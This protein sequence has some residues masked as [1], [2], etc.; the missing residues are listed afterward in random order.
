MQLT[1]CQRGTVGFEPTNQTVWAHHC[2]PYVSASSRSNKFCRYIYKG[3]LNST[4]L[5]NFGLPM[6]FHGIEPHLF[7]PDLC[8]RV[9]I[10]PTFLSGQ[11]IEPCIITSEKCNHLCSQHQCV[12]PF[13]HQII[14]YLFV[15]YCATLH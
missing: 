11:G 3:R 5:C 13:R 9:G 1:I 4:P 8:K 14:V 2:L 15:L 7:S 6:P 12:Y 10:E